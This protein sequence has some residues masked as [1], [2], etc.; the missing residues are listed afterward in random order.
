[1]GTVLPA[2]QATHITFSKKVGGCGEAKAVGISISS[3]G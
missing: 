2:L 3:S 1:M